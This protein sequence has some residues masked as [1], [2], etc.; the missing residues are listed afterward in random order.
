MNSDTTFREWQIGHNGTGIFSSVQAE[1]DYLHPSILPSIPE[2]SQTLTVDFISVLA[3]EV[4]NPLTIINLSVEMLKS[5]PLEKD[6]QVYLDIILR[7]SHRI[8]NMINELLLNRQANSNPAEKHS[9]QQLLE[10]VIE[11]IKDNLS[12]KNIVLV[13]EYSTP[14][15]KILLDKSKIKIALTNLLFNAI[16]AMTPGKGVIKLITKMVNGKYALL[17]KDNGSGISRDQMKHI[18]KPYFTTKVNGRGIGLAATYDILKTN[19]VRLKVQSEVGKGTR[20][21]LLFD[22]DLCKW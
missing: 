2:V 9:M 14:D 21:M 13:K 11:S 22:K 18:F 16:E 6:S 3:H 12:L 7:N 20:F 8:N 15:R 19:Q 4:R 10:E 17:I 1:V 5:S